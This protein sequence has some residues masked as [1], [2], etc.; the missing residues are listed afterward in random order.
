MAG[1]LVT[2]PDEALV[3]IAESRRRLALDTL[4]RNSANGLR[5]PLSGQE[6]AGFEA[7]IA[8]C[9]AKL[10]LLRKDRASLSGPTAPAL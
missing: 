9:D 6:I 4:A 8:E 1:M 2:E 10:V 3:L 5:V 7:E